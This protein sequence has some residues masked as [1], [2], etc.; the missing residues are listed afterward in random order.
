MNCWCPVMEENKQ[1]YEETKQ[2]GQT[3]IEW[4]QQQGVDIEVQRVQCENCPAKH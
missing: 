3:F 2:E 1:R 4:L